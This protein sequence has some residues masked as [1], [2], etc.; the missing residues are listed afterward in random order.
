L[1]KVVDGVSCY[2][3]QVENSPFVLV[4][5]EC[6]VEATVEQ[7][8]AFVRNFDNMKKMD[9]MYITGSTLEQFSPNDAILYAQFQL[10]TIFISN[11]DFVFQ[12]CDH[13]QEN[14]KLAVC[15]SASADS[16]N[17]PPVPSGFVRGH[18]E[19]S[20]FVIK[21]VEGDT[22]KSHVSYIVHVD[23]KGWLPAWAV[24]LSAVDQA[25]NVGR[26]KRH[27]ESAAKNQTVEQQENKVPASS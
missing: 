15:V 13:F 17:A 18:I 24:N 25:R 14:P 16:E 1:S 6:V 12:G 5:G 7:V 21:E 9:D 8:F 22:N 4:K 10:P 2:W 11:R 3:R 27:V 23:P 19:A 26:V 20:G